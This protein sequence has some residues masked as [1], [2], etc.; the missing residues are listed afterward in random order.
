[1][2][3]ACDGLARWI[4]LSS[5]V[6]FRVMRWI[7]CFALLL[8]NY[9]YL[10]IAHILQYSYHR[11]WCLLYYSS[12][13]VPVSNS[14]SSDNDDDDGSI[15][16]CGQDEEFLGMVGSQ[17]SRQASQACRG[18]WA[19]TATS[20]QLLLCFSFL[21]LVTFVTGRGD[22]RKILG[23]TEDIKTENRFL[24]RRKVRNWMLCCT[25][26]FQFWGLWV[27]KWGQNCTKICYI[28]SSSPQVAVTNCQVTSH[29]IAPAIYLFVTCNNTT[30]MQE[31]YL[32]LAMICV[33]WCWNLFRYCRLLRS[34]L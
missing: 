22:R 28:C 11:V 6:A 2:D 14:D 29:H 12:F 16:D 33:R 19:A 18:R 20:R 7:I 10:P 31:I 24:S 4:D 23:K 15:K 1:M 3:L 9:C 30:C 5:S 21:H 8:S 27:W 34:G 17:R 13:Y 32:M 25:S 26:V